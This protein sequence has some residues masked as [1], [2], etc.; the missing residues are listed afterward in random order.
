MIKQWLAFGAVLCAVMAHAQAIVAVRLFDMNEVENV[1]LMSR[2]EFNE[3]RAEIQEENKVFRKALANVKKNW[4]K[5]RADAIKA[6]DKEFPK[7]PSGN[8][9]RP[10]YFKEKTINGQEKANAWLAQNQGRINAMMSAQAAAMAQYN[11]S[12]SGKLIQGYSGRDDKKAKKKAEKDEMKAAMIERMREEIA[13]EMS[14][15]LKYNRPIPVHFI[16][17]PVAGASKQ[18]AE[19]IK[20]QEKALEAYKQRKEAAEAAGAVE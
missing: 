6:G 5:K 4:D 14:S 19:Q 8:F 10:R 15:L 12:A 3:L 17:D 16:Y 18:I 7:F 11:K 13:T 20:E 1:M 9:V 2:E